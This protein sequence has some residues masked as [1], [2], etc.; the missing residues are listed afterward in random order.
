MN[1]GIKLAILDGNNSETVTVQA[2]NTTNKTITA[3]FSKGHPTTAGQDVTVMALRGFAEGIVGARPLYTTPLAVTPGTY[4]HE[5]D[6]K[7]VHM[8]RDI[9]RDRNIALREAVLE[10]GDV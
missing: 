7:H 1:N 5:S 4:I 3:C 2:L 10:N 6:R 9:H 8:V